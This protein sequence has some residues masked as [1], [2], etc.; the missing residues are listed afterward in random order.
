MITSCSLIAVNEDTINRSCERNI[1][2]NN[3]VLASVIVRALYSNTKGS[4]S[5][6]L[7]NRLFVLG[8]R[9]LSVL[10]LCCDGNPLVYILFFLSV[11][12]TEPYVGAKP[13]RAQ[14]LQYY[15]LKIES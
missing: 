10:R 5:T 11:A 6:P 9:L 7:Y 3:C 4:A 2:S 1:V 13:P 8:I 15:P 14:G 12:N